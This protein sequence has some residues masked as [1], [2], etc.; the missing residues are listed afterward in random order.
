MRTKDKMIRV[1]DSMEKED[2]W[3]YLAKVLRNRIVLFVSQAKAFNELTYE[4]YIH[5]VALY[6]LHYDM[7]ESSAKSSLLRKISNSLSL[8]FRKMDKYETVLVYLEDETMPAFWKWRFRNKR[9]VFID[10][11]G[12][13]TE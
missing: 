6:A 10:R 4:I 13:I 3:K 2:N 7:V 11:D 9:V 8:I 12:K 5:K 1:K